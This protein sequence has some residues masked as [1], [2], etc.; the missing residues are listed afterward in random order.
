MAQPGPLRVRVVEVIR[1]TADAHSLV[2]EPADGDRGRFGYRPGQFL[3]I[4]IPTGRE[5]GTARCYSLCSS[6]ACDEK[7]KVTVKRVPGG[8]GSNWICDHVTEGDVLEVLRPSGAFTP[9]TLDGDLLLLAAG[10]GITPVMSILKSCLHAGTGS[11]VLVYANR[12]ENSVIFREELAALA[13]EHAG[14]LA[15]LHWLESVQGLPTAAGLAAVA[16]P[17]A[18]REAFVCGPGPFMDLAVEA[19]T[20]LGVPPERVRTERFTSLTADPFTARPA[21]G[22]PA[23]GAPAPAAPAL[24]VPASAAP[25]SDALVS[26]L[27]EASSPVAVPAPGS[28]G[29]AGPART[30]EAAEVEV[31]VEL[32]GRT[33]TVAWPRGARLLDVLLDAGLDAPYSCREGSCSACACVLVEG[34]VEMERNQV[35]DDR[36][37]ADGLILAC[38]AV[39]VSERLKVTYDA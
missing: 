25:V 35:L 31:E 12:D 15:V 8:H 33:R 21:P 23:P 10:S 32:D 36:D 13:R 39:P 11:A 19:L 16:G 30:A 1:E 3:T 34:E 29:P 22:A 18:G 5:G 7:L 4:R 14:R 24:G 20:G 37:L 38:Q 6:P 28:A 27:T 17:Y 9:R 26:G 2:L